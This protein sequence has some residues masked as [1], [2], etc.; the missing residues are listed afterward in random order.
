MKVSSHN[1]TQSFG[2]FGQLSLWVVDSNPI[3]ASL[4]IICEDKMQNFA[5]YKE[6]M[7]CLI[8]FSKGLDVLPP[9]TCASTIGNL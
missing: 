9:F 2:Q 6:Y 4:V 8:L 5:R 1:A 7:I 3:A